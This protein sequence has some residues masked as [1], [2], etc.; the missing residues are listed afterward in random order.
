MTNLREF[1]R[2]GLDRE[3]NNFI[4][5]PCGKIINVGCGNK[6]IKNAVG[7][8]YPEWDADKEPLPFKDN[9]IAGIHCYHFLE[10]IKDPV[11]MLLD[12]QRVLI[13]DGV[14]NIVVPYYNSQMMHHDLDHKKSFCEETWKILFKNPYYD[15]NKIEWKFIININFIFGL[16]ERNMSLFTQLVKKG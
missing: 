7:I 12:F 10:H 5:F 13:C 16:V 9:S 11:N 1:V 14:V 4:N 8:D 3:I 2:L 15:K 6:I